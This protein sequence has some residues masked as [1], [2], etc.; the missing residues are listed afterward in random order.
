MPRAKLTD[1]QPVSQDQG[2]RANLSD[3]SG[4]GQGETPNYGPDTTVVNPTA[5]QIGTGVLREGANL[6]SGAHAFGR[7]AL[8][9]IPGVSGSQFDQAMQRHQ[10]QLDEL[11]KPA[12]LGEAMGKTGGEMAS[13]LAPMK[14]ESVAAE[15]AE[16]LPGLLRPL[17]R[18][19]TSAV[20]NAAM[21][22]MNREPVGTGAAVGA[23]FGLLGEGGRL[24]SNRLMRSAIPGKI[25]SDTANALLN[26]TR[27]IRPSTVLAS[28]ENRIGQAGR[29][30]DSA[31]SNVNVRPTPRI[32][33]FLMPPQEEI[34]LAPAPAPRDPRMHPMAFD[35]RVNPEEPN[36]PRSGNPMADISEYPGINPHYL[37]GSE[38]PELSGRVTPLQNPQQVTTRMGTLLRRRREK[39]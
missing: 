3:V 29:D 34:P 5:G 23:A 32:A 24:L 2:G 15:G 13:Y 7:K 11:A 14:A 19:G 21:S 37:S 1:A 12:N 25:S 38:H 26:E 30:L 36:E 9:M 22:G 4:T 8:E 39:G 33:G 16:R 17:A 10:A 27:G 6:L 31:V 18:I 28:T 35:A 20:S